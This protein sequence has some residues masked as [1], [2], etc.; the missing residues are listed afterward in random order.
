VRETAAVLSVGLTGG[1][2]AGKTAVAARLRARGA[3]I[4]DADQLARE[5]VE[6]GTPGLR[7]VVEAF[8]RSV[9]RSDGALDRPELGRLVFA[10]DAARERLNRIVH[11]LVEAR[12]AEVLAVAPTDAVVVHDVPLL[13][14]KQM[15]SAYHLVVVVDAPVD[16]RLARLV[17]RGLEE[18]DARA[19]MAAQADQSARR[20]AADVWL[21][22]DAGLEA[23]HAAVD[24]LW[25]GRLVPYEANVRHRRPA[26]RPADVV[27]VSADPGWP[28]Q[29]ARLVG[30]LA[31]VGGE[32][33]LRVDHIGST[34]I[35]GLLAKDVIDLQ[36]TVR[37]LPDGDALASTLEE[38][39]FPRIAEIT[40]DRPKPDDPDPARWPK[41][42][43]R[44]ADPGRPANVHVRAAGSPGWRYA[45]LFRDWLR[46]DD[47]A[48]A[49]YQAEKVRLAAAEP[50]TTGYAEA[51]E[52][53]FDAAL[54]LAQRWAAEVG[55]TP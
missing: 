11:P 33:A 31:A 35:P 53:W 52:P 16:V 32:R 17:G 5:V 19:R 14:E 54:P 47:A 24:E 7:A 18:V 34:A 8:G 23:L 3:V 40:A 44:S 21:D 20:A 43:H 29:A 48:R 42:F 1:I 41:R 27:L 50:I 12:T 37:E 49:A 46:A 45:L 25:D 51:K 22:N 30:R 38:A 6:P 28:A 36:L 4:I 13:V 2:G 9:L 39:G 10:D 15:G 55:W 26:P